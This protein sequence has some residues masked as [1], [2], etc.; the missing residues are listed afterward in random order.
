MDFASVIILLCLQPYK[1]KK[2][3][4]LTITGLPN[5]CKK[6]NTGALT[7]PGLD[8]ITDRVI[9]QTK[10]KKRVFRVWQPL[11]YILCRNQHHH[12]QLE[13]KMGL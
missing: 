5:D 13:E 6:D 4:N 12:Y 8:R 1:Q 3:Q 10:E 2:N 11:V 7:K 9:D